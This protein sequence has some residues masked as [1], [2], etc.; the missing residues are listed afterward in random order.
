MR[1]Y[2]RKIAAVLLALALTPAYVVAEDMELEATVIS[3]DEKEI[4]VKTKEGENT[5]RI[6]SKTK[7]IEN[8]KE[9]AGDH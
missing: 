7:G 5:L 6:G 8:A 9:G 4:K 1:F 2:S 3:K